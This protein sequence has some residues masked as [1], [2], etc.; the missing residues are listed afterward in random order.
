M[1]SDILSYVLKMW[2]NKS[3]VLDLKTPLVADYFLT[4]LLDSRNHWHVPIPF[5]AL[6]KYSHSTW[7]AERLYV[8]CQRFVPV[9][10]SSY[11]LV[12]WCLIDLLGTDRVGT[13]TTSPRWSS[14]ENQLLVN[15]T[16]FMITNHKLTLI[17]RMFACSHKKSIS[18]TTLRAD[19][20]PKEP[21]LIGPPPLE[22]SICGSQALWNLFIMR[23]GWCLLCALCW[24][25]LCVCVCESNAPRKVY[26][27]F[28][29]ISWTE[30]AERFLL[31]AT[32][33]T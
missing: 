9:I 24:C 5:S 31:A 7:Q 4:W 29:Q 21:D 33:R 20:T 1:C 27:M 16:C 15:M 11:W 26:Y 23:S 14:N 17:L 12:G 25:V 6:R 10:K 32:T 19:V 8:Q 2:E 18:P 13:Q 30:A 3:L 22:E 28:E